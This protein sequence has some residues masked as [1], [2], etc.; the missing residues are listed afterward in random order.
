MKHHFTSALRLCTIAMLLVIGIFQPASSAY[1]APALTI[2]PITWNIIGL[3]SNTPASGPYLFPVGARICAA[4]PTT[5]TARFNWGDSNTT[6]INLRTGTNPNQTLTFTA[7][8]CQDAYFEVQVSQVASAYDKSRPYFITAENPG[9]IDLVSTPTP[10]E[11]Y[12]EHLISQNR[13]AITDIKLNGSSIPAGGTMTLMVGQ[14]L[15]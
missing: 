4:G 15:S 8:G 10:R 12:I 2:A 9:G 13:N 6:H 3:D 5:I 7:A 14:T 1:A 11:L